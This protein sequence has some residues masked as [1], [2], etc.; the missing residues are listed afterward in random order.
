MQIG[1]S[2]TITC[3]PSLAY[4]T[5]AFGPIAA[6]STLLF[7]IEVGSCVKEEEIDSNDTDAATDDSPSLFSCLLDISCIINHVE[8]LIGGYPGIA[9][10]YGIIFSLF[11]LPAISDNLFQMETLTNT[12]NGWI[13]WI[14]EF[15]NFSDA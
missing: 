13:I 6:D 3:P 12:F 4:G 8:I 11:G 5:N 15:F 7:D 1:Q 10:Y 2:A 14:L 9:F